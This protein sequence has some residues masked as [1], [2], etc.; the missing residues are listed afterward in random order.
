MEVVGLATVDEPGRG[1]VEVGDGQHLR[2]L[3]QV[4]LPAQARGRRDEA[5]GRTPREHPGVEHP[6]DQ[7]AVADKIDPLEARGAV[8]HAR[9]GQQG[10]HRA[11]AGVRRGVDRRPRRQVHADG[12]HPVQRHLRPVH[13]HHLSAGVEGQLGRGRAHPGGTAHHQHPLA[14]EPERVEQEPHRHRRPLLEV[15]PV[16]GRDG[17]PLTVVLRAQLPRPVRRVGRGRHPLEAD[18]ADT[19]P[20]IQGDR[21]VGDIGQLQGELAVEAGVHEPRRR[22]DQQAQAAQRRLALQA[23]H[24][25]VGQSHPLQGRAQYELARMQDERV[26]GVDLHQGG[27][28]RQVLLHVDMAH[29]VVAEHPE[30]VPQAQVHRRRLHRALVQRVDHN[31]AGVE[32]LPDGAVRQDHRAAPSPGS[33]DSPSMPGA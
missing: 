19:H 12:C 1:L 16:A 9:A 28:L 10:V 33:I 3:V 24:Q 21:Q 25:V 20:R 7:I 32:R 27:E 26:V 4:R 23:G 2:E 22:M 5:D 30:P 8:G 17:T 6:V 15:L 31:V 13:D 29:G 18:L 14:V 11:P